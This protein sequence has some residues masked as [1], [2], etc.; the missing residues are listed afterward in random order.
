MNVPNDFWKYVATGAIAALLG[1]GGTTLFN[2]QAEAAMAAAVA[3]Q[4]EMDSRDDYK[5]RVHIA[6]QDDVEDL[7]KAQREIEKSLARIEA[8]LDILL[9]RHHAE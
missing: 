1:S 7:E 8:S 6:I 4:K 5:A 3:V 9:N 2:G